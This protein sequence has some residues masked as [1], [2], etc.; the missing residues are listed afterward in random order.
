M[1]P[2]TSTPPGAVVVQ[3]GLSNSAADCSQRHSNSPT[4]FLVSIIIT[5]IISIISIMIS[6]IIFLTQHLGSFDAA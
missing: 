3:Y 2:S 4:I 1:S 5:I 6:I